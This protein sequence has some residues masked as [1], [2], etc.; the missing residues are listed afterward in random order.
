MKYS[1]IKPRVKRL[2]EQD[3]KIWITFLT[4]TIMIIFGFNLF[5]K[6]KIYQFNS[7]IQDSFAKEKSINE[8]IKDFE[9][10]IEFVTKQKVLAQNVYASNTIL[11]QSLKNL[12]EMIPDQITLSKVIISEDSLIMYGV[13]PTKDVYNFLLLAPLK[14]IFNDSM[15]TFYMNDDGWYK[16]VSVNKFSKEQF[17]NIAPHEED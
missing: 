8:Q 1:F 3:T 2:V 11:K 15:V 5:L 13:T 7:N 16:F 10:K 12:F 17:G 14:S 4:V 6:F 9:T